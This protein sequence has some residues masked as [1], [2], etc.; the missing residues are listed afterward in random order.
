[1][2]T[3]AYSG[4]FGSIKKLKLDN[5]EAV[6]GS[7]M[8][9]RLS[10]LPDEILGY[11]LSFLTLRDSVRT[12]LLSARWRYLSDY[13]CVL[14]FDALNVLGNENN[15]RELYQSKFVSV[16]DHY[17]EIW[18]G[19]N[20]SALKI[21]FCLHNKHAL[22]IDKWVESGIRME[23]EDLDLRFP[24]TN[25]E[26]RYVLS[27]QLFHSGKAFS[28]KCLRLRYCTLT[29][30]SGCTSWISCL[31]TL[32]LYFVPLC[33]EDIECL[34]S[35]GLNLTSLS[36]VHCFN[37]DISSV[38]ELPRLKKLFLNN[39]FTKIELKCPN[40]ESLKCEGRV[41]YFKFSN[42][43]LLKNVNLRLQY[44]YRGCSLTFEDLAIHAPKLQKLSLLV[45]TLVQPRPANNS[46]CL[47][48]L[49]LLTDVPTGFDLFTITSLLN[50]S[51]FLEI[52]HLQLRMRNYT[53]Q[54]PHIEYSDC[55]HLNL[56]EV[57][58]DGF[59]RWWNEMELARYLLKNAVALERMVIVCLCDCSSTIDGSVSSYCSSIRE[60][61]A[62]TLLRDMK[63][64]TELVF[65]TPIPCSVS[66]GWDISNY[67]VRVF[68]GE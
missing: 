63:T 29:F 62:T 65:T 24:S 54:S 58:I 27:D 51:P 8:T 50:A 15:N 42:V 6:L 67:G 61:I 41:D 17:L 9:D 14:H 35:G 20:L 2:K 1:M 43:P 18:K 28:F 64:S 49:E 25:P 66:N 13:R 44:H 4:N 47:K 45:M 53:K 60:E 37:T 40:L 12:R 11:M 34:M 19:W 5:S 22:H 56:K 68:C 10:A 31:A 23:V 55:P 30:S 7:M 52:L 46:L 36:L 59:R 32:E 3:L 26:E 48:R 21:H 33:Q 39:T 57:K 16:V 38:I